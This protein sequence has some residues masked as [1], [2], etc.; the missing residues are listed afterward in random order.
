LTLETEKLYR[1]PSQSYSLVA[2]DIV[3]SHLK[4]AVKYFHAI[5][6]RIKDCRRLVENTF[7]RFQPH[8]KV[9]FPA[10]KKKKKEFKFFAK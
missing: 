10:E 5:N 3:K 9:H 7:A 2:S 6:S 1:K 8:P 4:L